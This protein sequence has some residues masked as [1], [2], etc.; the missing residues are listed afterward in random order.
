ML[1]GKG[2]HTYE[3]IDNWAVIAATPTGRENGRTH[4]VVVSDSG[5]IFVFHQANPA[6]LVFNEDGRLLNAW[7][8]RFLGAHGMTLVREDGD[9]YLWLTDQDS[10]EVVKMTLD[11][12]TVM[13]LAKPNH[14]TYQSGK[15]SPTWVAV[16]EGRHGGNGDIWV[17]DGYGMNYVHRYNYRGN[18]LSSM[19]GDEGAGAFQCPHAVFF[20]TREGESESEL[21]VADRGNKRFQVFSADGKFN[22]SFGEHFLSCPCACQTNGEELYIPELT[23]KLV[24]L[25]SRDR[26]VCTL[27]DNEAS[28]RIEGWPNHPRSLIKEGK[29]NS[30]HSLAVDRSGNIYVVEWIIGGRITKLQKVEP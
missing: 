4:G 5:K 21:Y 27:G 19:N 17:A 18:Y 23:A 9:E 11:G 15:Y 29:F 7:G 14:P 28:C 26:H 13:T 16:N 12:V 20:D 1:I 2:K 25:D 8:D 22:R 3:W 10:P 24:V 6:V 30:P